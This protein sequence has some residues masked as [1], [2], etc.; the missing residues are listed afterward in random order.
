M[1]LIINKSWSDWITQTASCMRSISALGIHSKLHE[2]FSRVIKLM[3]TRNSPKETFGEMIQ[4]ILFWLGGEAGHHGVKVHDH[5]CFP[6]IIDGCQMKKPYFMSDRNHRFFL[7]MRFRSPS[8]YDIRWKCI[9]WLACCWLPSCC[10]HPTQ[11]RF[12]LAWRLAPGGR[13]P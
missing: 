6:R 9:C 8:P 5:A 2:V 13:L 4:S 7:R 12:L 10:W 11:F 3:V 1:S